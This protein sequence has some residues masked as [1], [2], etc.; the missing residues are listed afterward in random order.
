MDGCVA[1]TLDQS[2]KGQL[3]TEYLNVDASNK[4]QTK[5]TQTKTGLIVV[6]YGQLSPSK[7]NPNQCSLE[8][9]NTHS[10]QS[11]GWIAPSSLKPCTPPPTHPHTSNTVLV[12]YANGHCLFI[13]VSLPCLISI[14]I[15]I[16]VSSWTYIYMAVLGSM[17]DTDWDNLAYQAASI[18]GWGGRTHMAL[19]V[20]SD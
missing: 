15:T 14:I 10:V 7:I 20:Y 6:T 12:P 5:A 1:S 2:T 11:Y 19:V 16:W 8:C 4:L 9:R 3:A 18:E 13:S 17:S